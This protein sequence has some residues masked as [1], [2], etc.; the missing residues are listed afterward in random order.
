MDRYV[1]IITQ[2]VTAS[3]ANTLTFDK[4]DLGFNLFEGAAVLLQRLEYIF[5]VA[6]V[7]EMTTAGDDLQ[8]ALTNS[9]GLSNLAA[10]QLEIIDQQALHRVDLGTAASGS[11]R[12][13]TEIHDFSNLIGGGLLVPPRPLYFAINSNGLASAAT[14][15]FRMYFIVVRLKSSDYIEL[16]ETRR[17]FS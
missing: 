16:L 17:A 11:I 3:A 8:A 4:L 13:T 12:N 2:A 1:N 15:R 5:D 14:V 6:A 7:E 9:D 10:Q